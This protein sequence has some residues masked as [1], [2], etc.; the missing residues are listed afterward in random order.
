MSKAFDKRF[1]L[2]DQLTDELVELVKAKGEKYSSDRGDVYA[3]A[4][5]Y[6]RSVLQSVAAQ[7]PASMERLEQALRAARRQG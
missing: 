7:S 4:T 6:I 5:G 3:Y 1:E 2:A